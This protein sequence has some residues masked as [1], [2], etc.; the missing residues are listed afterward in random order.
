MTSEKAKHEIT[1]FLSKAG[2]GRKTV[3]FRLKDWGISRQRYWGT[4]IPIVY[5][6]KCGTVPVPEKDLPIKL[7]KE[8]KFGKGNP[9]TTNDKWVNTKCPKCGGKGKRE[10]DTMDTFVNSSW[11]FLRY[12]DSNNKKEIF[13]KK[14]V[15]YWN[16]VD[17]YIGGAEHAC[18]HLIYS[19]FYVKFLRDIGL[20]NFDEPAK[21]LFH[22][23]MIHAEGGE[24]MS[25]SKGNVINPSDILEKYGV[26][27]LR[28]FLISV[29]SPDKDF[30]WSE[31]GI[32][33]SFRFVKK[34]YEFFENFKEGKDSEKIILKLNSTIKNVGEYFENFD[35]RK[36]TIELRDL[37]ELIYEEGKASRETLEKFLK[38]ISPICPHLS[39]ELWEKLGNKKL[40]LKSSWPEFKE[41]EIGKKIDFDLNEKVI[42]SV[43][44]IINK[45]ELRGDKISKVH[46]YFV[47]FEFSKVNQAKLSKGLNKKILIY[48][49]QDKEKYDPEGK[50]K[51]ARPGIPGIWFE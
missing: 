10:T 20:L 28:F 5:C 40:I 47:P 30:E 11:Y 39:E 43:S 2:S 24:K 34:I 35:Y 26:D 29:A 6:E 49:V 16:P 4:P 3:N 25:K 18:M 31:K 38:L 12:A 21:K 23:G 27:S 51:K 46:L 14:K 33:G 19:R 45:L 15:N 13:E 48:S 50:S 36:A 22:Q 9:L 41:N 42:K 32:Q 37:F 44:K 17:T 7:P 1:E 8:V